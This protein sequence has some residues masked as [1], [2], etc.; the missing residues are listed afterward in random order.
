MNIDNSFSSVDR[1][2]E[3][4]LSMAVANQMMQTMNASLQQMP[5][6]ASVNNTPP[7]VSI[8]ISYFVVV[9]GQQAGPFNLDE[10]KKLI[11]KGMI[12][13]ETLIWKKGLTAWVFAKNIPEV[14]REILLQSK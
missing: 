2:M 3:F 13:G 12:D 5:T 11:S 1:L 8:T 10:I 14:N 9:D 4:G 6:P 7:I